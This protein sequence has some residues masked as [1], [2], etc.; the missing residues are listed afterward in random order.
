MRVTA[1]SLHAVDRPIQ[2]VCMGPLTLPVHGHI[3]LRTG[4][5][6]CSHTSTDRHGLGWTRS[7]RSVTISPSN[8]SGARR[9][10]DYTRKLSFTLTSV[11]VS[12]KFFHFLLTYSFAHT[13]SSSDS[14]LCTSITPSLLH[15]RLKTYLFHKSYTP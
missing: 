7:C 1:E 5:G 3:T 4:I 6:H 14:P 8:V 11:T 10:D 13:S 12:N 9:D 15:S 2:L